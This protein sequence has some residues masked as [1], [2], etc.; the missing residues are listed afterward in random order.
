MRL[1]L[2]DGLRSLR[3]PA[4]VRVCVVGA[5]AGAD[6]TKADVADVAVADP[7]LFD[8]VTATRNV[9]RTSS[10]WAV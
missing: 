10:V 1:K 4:N 9:P 6:A 8:E 2:R 7:A 3:L 5:G